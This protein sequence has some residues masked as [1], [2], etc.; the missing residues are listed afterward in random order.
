MTQKM[1]K[2][3][4]D[5]LIRIVKQ[6]EK[7]AKAAASQRSA[8]LLA[9]FEQSVTDLHS[10]DTNEVWSAAVAAAVAAAKKANEEVSFEAS[11]L[12][13]PEEFRPSLQ[14]HWDRRGQAE[15]EGRRQELRR[16]AKAEIETLEKTA[17]VM[18]EQESLRAQT[19]IIRSGLDSTA[20][21]A[22]I[23]SL[24]SVDEIMPALDPATIQQKLVHRPPRSNHEFYLDS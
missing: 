4:R 8:V 15:Y 1:T 18:V 22:F 14:F 6:R 24:P 11:R 10:F 19:E 13:I 12:G 2:G 7:V 23:D 5:D 17:R 21:L 16:V 9:D 20:A 3:E